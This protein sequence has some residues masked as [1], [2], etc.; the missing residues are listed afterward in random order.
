MG[1]P[2]YHHLPYVNH[3][4]V[5]LHAVLYTKKLYHNV[6]T[7]T[8][9]TAS[10]LDRNAKDVMGQRDLNT[11]SALELMSLLLIHGIETVHGAKL[12]LAESFR[13]LF[14]ACKLS[15]TW[16]FSCHMH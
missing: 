8:E 1:Q 13:G 9:P 11:L 4:T 5:S 2:D 14:P 12:I 15:S 3:Y 10:S 7:I 6:T 16:L